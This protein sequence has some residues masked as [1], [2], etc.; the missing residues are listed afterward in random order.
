MAA[1]AA[2]GV[3]HVPGETLGVHPHQ[4]VLAPLHVALHEGD[5]LQA[6]DLVLERDD[7]ELAVLRGHGGLRHAPHEPLVGQAIG[8]DLGDGDELD[9]VLGGEPLQLGAPGHGAVLVHD[10]T[11]HARRGQSGQ[12]GQVDGSLGLPHAAQDAPRDRPEREHV[13]GPTQ[14]AR[15]RL[16]VHQQLDGLRPIP[17]ADTGRDAEP[18]VSVHAYREGR[19]ERLGVLLRHERQPQLLGPCGGQRDADQATG[20]P[21]HEV[22]RF[23]GD[24]GG[25][26]HQVALVLPVLVIGD[27]HHP[28]FADVG[29]RFFDGV[30]PHRGAAHPASFWPRFFM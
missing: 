27:D 7:L 2:L 30:E 19:P 18:R 21:G 23:R 17:G 10:L 25:G 12:A 22:D 5:V 24:P 26:D 8:H 29:D 16:R 11:D 20:V 13:P 4:D 14:V 28:A 15:L 3:E 1:V 9:R 6:V